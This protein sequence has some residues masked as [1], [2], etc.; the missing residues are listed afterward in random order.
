MVMITVICVTSKQH[1]RSTFAMSSQT[2]S[3]NE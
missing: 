2:I 1:Y 3:T